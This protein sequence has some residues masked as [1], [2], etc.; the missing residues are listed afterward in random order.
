MIPLSP[1]PAPLSG[2]IR[3]RRPRRRIGHAD[4]V[5]C[6]RSAGLLRRTEPFSRKADRP[7]SRKADRRMR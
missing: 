3:R 6:S 4:C 1:D 5:A 7:F 2:S